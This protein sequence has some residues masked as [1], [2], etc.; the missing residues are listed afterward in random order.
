MANIDTKIKTQDKQLLS[1]FQEVIKYNFKNLSLLKQALTHRSYSKNNSEKLE[2]LGDS[3]LNMIIADYLY[4]SFQN[5][6][7]GELTRMRSN[8]V[9]GRT[10]SKIALDLKVNEF[11]ILGQGELK[12][13]GRL[14]QSSLEDA[15]E[16]LTAAIYIDS[17]LETT[18]QQIL[19]WFKPYLSNISIENIIKDPKSKLQ[20]LIQG[21][22][23]QI[24]KYKHVKDTGNDH[25]RIFYAQ[26]II[27]KLNIETTGKGPNKRSAEQDAAKLALEKMNTK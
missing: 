7:E 12:T 16:A 14:R 2:F 23:K 11:L 22:L 27:S 1:N 13:N 19:S 20:E 9:N 26:C 24:P 18:Q 6:T 15:I 3:V 25:E 10:L 5:A 21:K 17:D 4:K 8:L